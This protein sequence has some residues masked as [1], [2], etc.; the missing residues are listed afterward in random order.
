MAAAAILAYSPMHKLQ[1]ILFSGNLP[2]TFFSLPERLYA[3][4]PYRP[5]ESPAELLALLQQE[6]RRHALILYTDNENI[7]LMGIFPEGETQAFFGFWETAEDLALNQ[8]AFALLEADARQRGCTMLVGPQHFNTFHRYRLRLGD[9]PSWQA[10]DREPVN[11]PYYPQLLERLGFSPTLTFESRLIQR[12]DVPKV[13]Q[14]K[15]LFLEGLHQL[16][17]AFIPLNPE[18]WQER[19]EEIYELVQA[20]FGQNP[21][22]RPITFAAFR[23]LYNLAWARR[24]CPHSSVLFQEKSSGRLAAMS[25]CH[26]NYRSLQAPAG[27]VPTFAQ[28]FP[29]LSRKTLLAKSVGVHPD[30]RQQQLMSYLAA[31]A[32]LSFQELYDEVLF[33]LMRSDNYSL[34]FTRELPYERVGYALYQKAL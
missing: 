4:L 13:Y 2:E 11:L 10:F 18:S 26:P 17:F 19:E 31:Y 3:G 28:D 24:L 15:Q 5:E 25:F 14:N 27:H 16:P 30:F 20:I 29:K 12:T 21:G 32:M 8:E 7:R 6:S 1:R 33:C 34:Q 23:R 22:Y 9:A